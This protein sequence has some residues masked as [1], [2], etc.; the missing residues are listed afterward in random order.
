MLQQKQSWKTG[1]LLLFFFFFAVFQGRLF[2]PHV[3]SDTQTHEMRKE[4][5]CDRLT[6]ASMGFLLSG[7]SQLGIGR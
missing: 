4:G 6:K 2:C 1:F 7:V 5:L 3:P